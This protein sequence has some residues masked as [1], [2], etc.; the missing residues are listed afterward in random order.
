MTVESCIKIPRDIFFTKYSKRQML[1]KAVFRFSPTSFPPNKSSIIPFSFTFHMT[2]LIFPFDFHHFSL[3]AFVSFLSLKFIVFFSFLYTYISI[4]VFIFLLY[5]YVFFV[6]FTVL[7]H[8]FPALILLF[9]PVSFKNFLH[10]I[11][12]FHFF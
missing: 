12:L 7:F 1:V 2:F 10:S 11:F 3:P 9:S 6:I 5:F 4:L 8:Y